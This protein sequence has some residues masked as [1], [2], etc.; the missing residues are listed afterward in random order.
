M[1]QKW[2][3]GS[4]KYI[5]KLIIIIVIL[6]SVKTAF[7]QANQGT[8]QVMIPQTQ[9]P[10]QNVFF[11]VLWGS[12]IGGMLRM[13]WETIDDS[14]PEEERYTVSNLTSNFAWGATVG[15]FMGLAAGIYLSMRGITFDENLTKIAFFPAGNPGYQK[16]YRMA[17]KPQP[18]EN[19]LHLIK[20]QFKF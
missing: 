3:S 11:N 2:V 4:A 18:V 16:L 9:P 13:G 19:S 1:Y 17:T 8:Q 6:C 7:G 5:S 15:G 20:F 14:K 10:M 12:A